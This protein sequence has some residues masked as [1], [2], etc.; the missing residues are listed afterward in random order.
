MA[1]YRRKPIEIDA[2]LWTGTNLI[3]ALQFVTTGDVG[4]SDDRFTLKTREGDS[5]AKPGDYIVRS[6]AGVFTIC[7]A[8]VF[9]QTYEA[10]EP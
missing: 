6:A 2:I 5:T 10:V 7:P 8:H 1:R 9:E 4:K 3:D